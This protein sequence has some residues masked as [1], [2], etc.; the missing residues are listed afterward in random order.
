M[1]VAFGL[2]TMA[3]ACALGSACSASASDAAEPTSTPEAPTS[4][5]TSA[6]LT[7]EEQVEEAYLA[8]WDVY[9]HALDSLDPTGLDEVYAGE[10]LAIRTDEIA[11]LRDAGTNVIGGVRHDFEVQLETDTL[12]IVVESYENHLVL[13][14]AATG[15]PLEE[16]PNSIVSRMYMLELID[17]TWKVTAALEA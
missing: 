17:G 1:R 10:A 14:D 3:A 2:A 15:Q 7:L 8:S 16:D 13:T 6:V 4:T 12:A 11:G 9:T 5:S